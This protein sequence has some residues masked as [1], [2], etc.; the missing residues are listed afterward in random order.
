[1][2]KWCNNQSF[3]SEREAALWCLH[4]ISVE[5]I[6]LAAAKRN[7]LRIVHSRFPFFFFTRSHVKLNL[8]NVPAF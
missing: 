7:V 1:M 5:I 6:G 4:L 8:I 3:G 2:D